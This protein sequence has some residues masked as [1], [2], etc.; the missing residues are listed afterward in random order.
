M[1]DLSSSLPVLQTL[2]L[3]YKDDKFKVKDCFNILFYATEICMYKE[4]AA[5]FIWQGFKNVWCL[6]HNTNH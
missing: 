3:Q 2:C 4:M 6:Q 1:N 5:W